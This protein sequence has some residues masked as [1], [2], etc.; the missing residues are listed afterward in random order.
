MGLLI[1]WFFLEPVNW[2]MGSPEP[3]NPGF[4][5]RFSIVYSK[6]I[7][8]TF[9]TSELSIKKYTDICHIMK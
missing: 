1:Y 9:P 2:E 8:H 4:G 6:T 3:G 7:N 5:F